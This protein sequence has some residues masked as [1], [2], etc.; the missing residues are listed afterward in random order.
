DGMLPKLL[1]APAAPGVRERLETMMRAQR[2]E[3]V[4]AA[5]RGMALRTDGKDILSRFHGPCMV[6]VGEHDQVTPVERARLIQS[7]VAGAE[8]HLVPGAAHLPNLEQPEHFNALLAR[9]T[10]P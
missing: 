8:L 5:S 3:A 7:L 4:A 10:A 9:F 6:I 2:R 1:H